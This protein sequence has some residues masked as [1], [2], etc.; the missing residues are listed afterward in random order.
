[1]CFLLGDPAYYSR[2]GYRPGAFGS[3][4]AEAAAIRPAASGVHRRSVEAHDVEALAAL[5][6]A[7]EAAVD[8][9]IDP[10]SALLEWV[11]PHPA[12]Q[13]NVYTSAGEVVGYT[14]VHTSEKHSPR[15]FLARDDRAAAAIFHALAQDAG[16]GRLTLP[17]HPRSRS[18]RM[19]PATCQAWEAGMACPLGA[20]PFEEY[21][22]QVQSGARVP[23][24][25]VWPVCFD[26]A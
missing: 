4:F 10:G 9:A 21:Y 12:V 1:V 7:E 20:S 11:S 8:F 22:A 26:L 23:G 19:I 16:A 5:W 13:A 2:F 24:R 17:L 3:A 14:R 15:A 6:R 18:A 25:P